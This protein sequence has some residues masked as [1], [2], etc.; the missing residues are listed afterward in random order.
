MTLYVFSLCSGLLAMLYHRLCVDHLQAAQVA[1][2]QRTPVSLT[3]EVIKPLFS[4]SIILF[5]MVL[6]IFTTLSLS[7][8][9][10]Q[11]T[12]YLWASNPIGAWQLLC[13][14][15]LSLLAFVF[16]MLSLM[17]MMI[18]TLQF[19][20][21]LDWGM[22]TS[23]VLALILIGC[24]FISFGL[25]ISTHIKNS[26][27][28]IGITFLGNLFWMLLEWLNPFPEQGFFLARELS[29]LNH[30]HHLF[31]GIIHSPDLAF[32]GLSSLFFLIITARSLKQQLTQ[33]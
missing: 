16:L 25:F 1:L 7:Q 14:K 11:Q 13:G 18:A 6:P 10:R 23:S 28:A 3:E 32:Y 5:A 31:H 26:L 15:F 19:E 17:L 20:T 33:I 21:P 8:E 30:T 24:C 12:I 22:I 29:L 9:F 2:Q 4:W 27:F